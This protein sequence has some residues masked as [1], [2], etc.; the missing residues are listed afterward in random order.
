MIKFLRE[1]EAAFL[2]SIKKKPFLPTEKDVKTWSSPTELLKPNAAFAQTVFCFSLAGP[3]CKSTLKDIA[4]KVDAQFMYKLS[5]LSPKDK[6]PYNAWLQY[7]ADT[8][9]ACWRAWTRRRSEIQKNQK[10]SMTEEETMASLTWPGQED[11]WY[12]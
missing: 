3:P 8:I 4:T 2:A 1:D 11:I 9:F 5:G 10:A 6:K 12:S 7:E